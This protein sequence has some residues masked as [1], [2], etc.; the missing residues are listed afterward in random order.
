MTTERKTGHNSKLAQLPLLYLSS[1][2][3]FRILFILGRQINQRKR[4][5]RKFA[6]R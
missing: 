4:Q 2:F 6:K 5:L 3:R 1:A